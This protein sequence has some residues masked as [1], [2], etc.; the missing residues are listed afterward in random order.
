MKQRE[1]DPIERHKSL[2]KMKKFTITGGK[3]NT[4]RKPFDIKGMSNGMQQNREE[5]MEAPAQAQDFAQEQC[6]QE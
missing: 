3:V 6:A 1:L 2:Y 5:F 4:N